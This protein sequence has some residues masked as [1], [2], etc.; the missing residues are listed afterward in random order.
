MK[1]LGWSEVLNAINDI[2][3]RDG[4]DDVAKSMP[5]QLKIWAYDRNKRVTANTAASKSGSLAMSAAMR[6]ARA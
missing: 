5:A 6:R 4:G 3:E 1:A 2:S